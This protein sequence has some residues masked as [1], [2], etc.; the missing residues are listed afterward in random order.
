MAMDIPK[1]YRNQYI[2]NVIEINIIRYAR[3]P[4]HVS[5]NYY[6]FFIDEIHA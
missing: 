6:R 1:C 5:L 4:P 2:Q 3:M